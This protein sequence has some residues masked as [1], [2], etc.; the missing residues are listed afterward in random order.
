MPVR[1]PALNPSE[2]LETI[3]LYGS[4]KSMQQ[5][6]DHFQVSIDAVVYT[7]RKHSIPR[8]T[9]AQSNAL[10]FEA[11]KCSYQLK[12]NLTPEEEHLK[13]AAVMLY[14]A[15]GYKVGKWT[16]DFANSDPRMAYLFIRFLK[17]ICGVSIRRI[18]C[19]LYCYVGQDVARLTDFWSDLL[20][21]PVSQFTKPYIKEA[22]PGP[23]GPRMKLGLVHI[24]Y[25]DKKL[26]RQ[27]LGWIDEYARKCVDGGVVNR[28]WL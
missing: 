5:V 23:R 9:P 24:R 18:R 4:G 16:I 10:R 22:K 12:E 14:W 28:D 19:S 6:A 3:S 17:E 25:C 13:L 1:A 21:I 27:I 7:L 26:L 15:E 20:G 2:Q 11:K 8:R